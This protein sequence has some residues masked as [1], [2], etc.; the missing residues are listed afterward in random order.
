MQKK[1]MENNWYSSLL[2]FSKNL[3]C[4]SMMF[5]GKKLEKK[6]TNNLL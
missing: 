5:N 2:E 3:K 6:K 1:T 4:N